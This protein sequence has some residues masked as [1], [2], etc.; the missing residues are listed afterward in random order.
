V[1]RR[2]CADLSDIAQDRALL[3]AFSGI[4][5]A[6]GDFERI[7][8]NAINSSSEAQEAG[9]S[10]GFGCSLPYDRKSLTAGSMQIHYAASSLIKHGNKD[11][12]MRYKSLV[13][14]CA[15]LFTTAAYA[16]HERGTLKQCQKIKDR[17]EKYTNLRRAGGTGRQMNGWQ[18]KRNYYKEQYAEKDCMRHRNHLK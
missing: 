18:K 8:I 11:D 5:D 1:G 16:G 4:H 6:V 3:S 17:I 9:Q 15:L 7:L 12:S 10:H 2:I 13:I 14:L